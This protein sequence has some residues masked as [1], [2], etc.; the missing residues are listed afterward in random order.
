MAHVVSMKYIYANRK[1]FD[2]H[3][4]KLQYCQLNITAVTSKASVVY[5]VA[6]VM[7]I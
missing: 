7:T 2:I 3:I 5:T 1:E 6:A 4:L